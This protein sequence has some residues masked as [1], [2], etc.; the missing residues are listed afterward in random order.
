MNIRDTASINEL[1]VL[2][3]LESLNAEMIKS[4]LSKEIRFNKLL[5]MATYQLTIL[6]EKDFMKALK[7]LST[8][9]YIEE[10]ERAKKNNL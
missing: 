9:T 3:N 4:D 10:K 1:A 6:N 5:N 7:K 8:A 2:S